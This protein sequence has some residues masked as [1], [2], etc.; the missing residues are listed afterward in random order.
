M[1]LLALVL[2]A[3]VAAVR[4]SR[5][6][7]LSRLRAEWGR[8][9]PRPRKPEDLAG[10]S[11]SRVAA[12][13][14]TPALDERTWNDLDLDE[15]FAAIDRT[16]STLGR[17]ALYHR[18]RS[19]PGPRELEAFETLVTRLGED[20]SARER[21]QLALS[22][23]QDPQGYALWWLARPDA[24]ET[25]P[26][27]ALFPALSAVTL[28]LAAATPLYPGLLP[29]LV[30]SL[31][32]S[33]AVRWLTDSSIG[34]ASAAFRQ[35]APVIATGEALQGIEALHGPE[36]APVTGPLGAGLA[37]LAPLK[38]ISR[39]ISGNP[40]M[41]SVSASPLA[42]TLGD[43]VNAVY[44]YLNLALL[45][46]ANGVFFGAAALRSRGR[47]LL[48][49]VAAIGDV[50]AAISVASLRAERSDWT[51]PRFLPAGAPALLEEAR[52]PLVA[53][54][55]PN[56]ATLAAGKGLLVTGSNM[57]GKTTFLRTV[58]VN[59]VLAQTLHTALASRYE[60]PA[61]LVRSCIGR[62]DD[63]PGGK[64]YYLVEVEALLGLVTA[65]QGAAPHLFLLDELFRGT[66][67]VERIAAGQAVLAELVGGADGSRPHVVLA[68]THDGE[69]VDL[70]EGSYSPC[71][72]GDAVV[73]DQLVFDHRL[74]PGRATSRNAIAI[75]RM[76]GAPEA[77]V[78]RALA[79]AAALDG[80]RA[81]LG[82]RPRAPGPLT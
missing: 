41:L 71:H 60:A 47:A 5:R 70:L 80:E 59:V 72:F 18:L 35:L 44:E 26:W 67:A 58:G 82:D 31:V 28:L 12:L 51:R 15:V 30:G 29:A 43:L 79:T 53:D 33:L 20:A 37:R 7:A 10:A 42:L 14:E 13:G 23:L 76:R 66:N 40:L 32:A 55:V 50:D 77:M 69:L 11:R 4:G 36:T 48:D 74:R 78:E 27:F 81:R 34:R 63:L 56:S 16:E 6:K 2:A 17:E 22:R 24:I 9:V 75:L 57:S 25:R 54:A 73:D 21:A 68:A 19:G 3:V 52:H 1:G 62:A 45:L 65:S 49:V 39:W 38:T 8:P 64:S 46:D 61:L